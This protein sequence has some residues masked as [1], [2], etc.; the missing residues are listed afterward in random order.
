MSQEGLRPNA[1]DA[2]ILK[3]IGPRFAA[4]YAGAV[5]RARLPRA[6]RQ[7]RTLGPRQK[8]DVYACANGGENRWRLL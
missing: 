3:E 5:A 4:D 1:G 6:M 8:H 7:W 2:S